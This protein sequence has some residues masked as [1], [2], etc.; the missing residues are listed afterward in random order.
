M[1]RTGEIEQKKTWDVLGN[2]NFFVRFFFFVSLYI[3][4]TF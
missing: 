2:G 4:L 3:F 1:Q